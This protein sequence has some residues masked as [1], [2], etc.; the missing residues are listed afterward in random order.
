MLDDRREQVTMDAGSTLRVAA[1]L[2]E[3]ETIRRFVEEQAAALRIDP[4]ATYD[5]ML[6]VNEIVA[7]TIIHGY[8]K[9]PGPIEVAV[10]QVGDGCEIRVRDQAPPFD[11]TQTP[12]P[13]LHAP[14][15]KR[16]LGGMGIYLARQ[17]MDSLAYRATPDGGNE[18]TLVKHRIVPRLPQEE[19][20]GLDA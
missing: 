20:D 17:L 10:R 3:L 7:N 12:L 5:L 9:Q 14:L 19:P 2:S 16:R 4:S 1:K 11:P 13:D 18:V 8:R 6:A 15:A